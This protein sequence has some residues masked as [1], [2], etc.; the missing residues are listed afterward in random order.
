MLRSLQQIVIIFLLILSLAAIPM[1]VEVNP[2]EN[3]LEW[4]FE[5]LPR[6]YGDFISEI[7]NGSLGTYQLGTQQREIAEDI[8]NNF[9]TSLKIMLIGVN[10]SIII[11][12]IFG[13]FVSRFRLTKLFNFILNL[14]S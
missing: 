13:I 4:H 14:L 3:R 7:S 6:I 1:I 12:L 8:R 10:V 2:L 11:S 5:K 9:F